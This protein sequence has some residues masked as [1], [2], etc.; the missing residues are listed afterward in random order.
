LNGKGDVELD[1]DRNVEQLVVTVEIRDET[2]VLSDKTW[3]V[4]FGLELLEMNVASMSAPPKRV[5]LNE[6]P[7]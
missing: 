7:Y 5:V 6:S 1:L 3:N 2:V 4:V